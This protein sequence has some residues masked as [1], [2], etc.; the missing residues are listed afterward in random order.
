[1]GAVLKTIEKA[2]KEVASMPYIKKELN[3]LWGLLAGTS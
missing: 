3:K 2:K 1:M